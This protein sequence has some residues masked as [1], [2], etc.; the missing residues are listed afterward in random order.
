M[1]FSTT[2]IDLNSD[3]IKP[4]ESLDKYL[5]LIADEFDK[6]FSE[7]LTSN[8][9]PACNSSKSVAHFKKM[10][11]KYVRCQDC[12]TVYAAERP[13]QKSLNEFYTSSSARK[14]WLDK[15]WKDSAQTRMQ[16]IFTPT[17]D[18]ICGHLTHFFPGN[19][20]E[21]SI[22][23]VLANNPGF[24]QHWS[25]EFQAPN[26][27]Q[28]CFQGSND[29]V[30]SSH[31]LDMTSNTSHQALTLFDVLDRA[32]SPK[33]VLSWA[34][35]HLQENGLCFV[36]GILSSGLD[37]LVL[38]EKSKAVSPPDRLNSFSLEGFEHL[39]TSTGFEVVELSTPGALDVENVR[40]AL[41][42]GRFES[43]FFN[44]L[45]NHRKDD[46]SSARNFQ[47]FLQQNRLSSRLRAVLKRK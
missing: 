19:L 28:A 39:A 31:L 4:T 32:E 36:T 6:F 24:Y 38:K 15:I 11:T 17:I 7:K 42:D 30:E 9:C 47:Q 23:D 34:K 29:V 3:E 46:R 21:V 25:A 45:L 14:F 40:H 10:S 27:I 22:A 41:S 5:Q 44:Y 37:T 1:E 13:Q 2:S 18:W 35:E 33:D 8:S 43:D 16:K 26:M 12:F 20:K